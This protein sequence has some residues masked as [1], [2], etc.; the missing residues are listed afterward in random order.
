[1][2]VSLSYSNIWQTDF[3]HFHH[4]TFWIFLP[5]TLKFFLITWHITRAIWYLS[6]FSVEWSWPLLVLPHLGPRPSLHTLSSP[7]NTVIIFFLNA[8][9]TNNGNISSPKDCYWPIFLPYNLLKFPYLTHGEVLYSVILLC[10]V[11]NRENI[12]LWSP[13]FCH[14]F[15]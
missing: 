11:S 9:Q 4:Y 7:V 14:N 3:N 13:I 8:I 2:Y 6:C 5:L 10:F 1:M 12:N 15:L